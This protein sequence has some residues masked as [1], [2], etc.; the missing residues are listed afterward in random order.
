[1]GHDFG[2]VSPN[3]LYKASLNFTNAGDDTLRITKIDRC[4]GVVAKLAGGKK[5][6]APGEGGTIQLEWR[7][8]T[9]PMTFTGE[10]V[11]HTDDKANLV[12]RLKIRAKIMLKVT[13]EPK[14]LR[15]TLD[16]DTA[17]SQNIR[18]RCL[19]D[20]PF[21][22]TSF[23]S[24][25][26]SIIADFDPSAEATEFVLEPKINA[27]NLH[28]NLKGRIT[29]GLTHPDCKA[30]I[31]LFDVLR[32]YTISPPL[33][34]IFDAE[35]NKPIVRKISVVNNYRKDFGVDSLSSKN[36]IV[37][38][39]VLGKK[40]ITNGHLVEVELTPPASGDKNG[41]MDELYLTLGDGEKLSI[42]CHMYY[43]KIKPAATTK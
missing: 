32:E 20:R 13:W 12:S 31:V 9:E 39:R 19:D 25:G 30:A 22:I 29:V 43:R 3:K 27:E 24:T 33:L 23:K 42:K 40:E 18:I 26:D 35:P 4:Y 17:S 10:L 8:G 7:S 15:L 41:F 36:G 5:E 1:M 11:V 6:Y 16:D 14:R 28:G 2:E 21:S 34:L 37:G 38:T